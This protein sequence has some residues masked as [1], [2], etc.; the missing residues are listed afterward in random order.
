MNRTDGR[1]TTALL[2]DL[3]DRAADVRRRIDALDALF[4]SRLEPGTVLRHRGLLVS[5]VS[6]FP[7]TGR[8]AVEPAGGGAIL[9]VAVADLTAP[10]DDPDPEPQP[11]AAAA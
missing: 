9:A 5:V 2:R 7:A 11:A 4:R 6:Y 8:V 3:G 10:G 1:L